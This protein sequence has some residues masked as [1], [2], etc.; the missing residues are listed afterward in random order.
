MQL[1]LTPAAGVGAGARAGG[2]GLVLL[3]TLAL[4]QPKSAFQEESRRFVHIE[5]RLEELG[6]DLPPP[7]QPKAN[8]NICCYSSTGSGNNDNNVLYVSGHLPTNVKDGTLMTGKIGPESEGGKSVD[9]GYDAARM[10]GLAIIST[11]KEQLGD[12]DKVDQVVKVSNCDFCY[13]CCCCEGIVFA[14]TYC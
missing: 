1:Q 8:Y 6:I 14:M 7:S 4:Q 10:A 11:L 12:L 3:R 13:S 2:V 5:K 9:H